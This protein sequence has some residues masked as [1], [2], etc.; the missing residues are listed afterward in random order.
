MANPRVQK[1]LNIQ[2][3][4]ISK[5]FNCQPSSAFIIF[6]LQKIYGLDDFEVEEAITDG[7]NDKGIDAIFSQT[8]E[9]GNRIL[10]IVQSKY[11]ENTDKC[12]DETA[13]TLM[14]ETI[15]NY[16]LG[17]APTDVLNSKLKPRIESAR[18]LR[19][20]GEID[21]VRLLFITNGQRPQPS[22]YNDLERF[23]NNQQQV[24]FQIF[25][26]QEISELLLPISAR[27]VGDIS[28]SV[29]KDT[30]SGDRTFLSL[31]DIDY[32]NGKIVRID[33]YNI[34]KLVENNPNIFNA[35]V[36]GFLGVNSVNRGILATLTDEY[37]IKK[38]AYLNNGITILCD[39]YQIKPGGEVIE[40]K[41]P[42][43]I[44][45]CQ[46]ASTILEAY[47][48]EKIQ[49]NTGI[50][51]VR[52]IQSSDPL[53]KEAI[54]KASNTQSVVKNRDL[55]SEDPIQKE[56]EEQFRNMGYIYQRKR[57]AT[58]DIVDNKKNIID[59]E[60]SAQAYM[61]LFLEL[62]AEAKN[63]KAEIYDD[64]YKE[65]F[66][67]QISANSLLISSYILDL[68]RE[69]IKKSKNIFPEDHLSLFGN[70]LLHFLPLF[71]KWV[72][73]P[74]GIILEDVILMHHKDALK[75]ILEKFEKNSSNILNRLVGVM[76]KIKKGSDFKNYQYFFKS[77]GSLNK[78]LNTQGGEVNYQI[79][80]NASNYKRHVD[81]RYTKPAQYSLDGKTFTEG[82]TWQDLFIELLNI[83]SE[84]YVILEGDLDFI[85]NGSRKLLVSS[86]DDEERKLRKKLNNNLWL[87]TNFDS[88]RLCSFCFIISE[89]LNLSLI[90]RLRSTK[91]RIENGY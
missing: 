59:L 83:Y 4:S 30:G 89:K 42:S 74:E 24:D 34:A 68:F 71:N 13:K 73:I 9:N 76:V 26:E 51:L 41:N 88:K 49:P 56:L 67:N 38:F 55:I 79:E 75:I 15:T 10:Y 22:L 11:F 57:G 3:Q 43:I 82:E 62:P 1:S 64:Y 63:K 77:S 35:N 17:D 8:T 7:G 27:P 66:H 39:N 78:I 18:E 84:K 48:L 37:S 86:I 50:V 44:N 70:A 12:L 6:C 28:L 33:V 58:I 61:S 80:L 19:Q 47:K 87:L 21:K 91:S 20:S 72:L 46:T 90:I 36:R 40:V 85:E 54:I 60:K 32:A 25:T 29:I 5:D 53:L 16:V 2:V 23:C 45:G 31:P 52:I 14:V 81:L 65:I 69:K